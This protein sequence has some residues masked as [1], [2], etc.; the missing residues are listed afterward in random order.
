MEDVKMRILPLII[1]VGQR[2]RQELESKK[3]M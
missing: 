1:Q 3:K 2:G